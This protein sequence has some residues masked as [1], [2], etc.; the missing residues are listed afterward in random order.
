MATAL[1]PSRVPVVM[2]EALYIH[3]SFISCDRC[4]NGG[5]LCAAAAAA[6]RMRTFAAT[7]T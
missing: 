7:T 6:A 5:G 2:L 3:N 1:L 4:R